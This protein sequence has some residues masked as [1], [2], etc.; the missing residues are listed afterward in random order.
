MTKVTG[1]GLAVAVMMA[2][3]GVRGLRAEGEQMPQGITGKV[4]KITGNLMPGPGPTGSA[5]TPLAVPVHIFKGKVRVFKKPDPEH[6]QLVKTLQAGKDGSFWTGLPP[7]EYTVVAEINGE[8]YLNVQSFDG[9]HALW[10]TV[11]VKEG[12]WATTLIEDTRGA[13]F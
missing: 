8:L 6:P 9:K 3:A 11:E 13:A 4:V 1:V 12:V 7:G 10:A 2:V 5:K